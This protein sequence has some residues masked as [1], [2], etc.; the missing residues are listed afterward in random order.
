M[1]V[2]ERHVHCPA[3]LG[4]KLAQEFNNKDF[5]DVKLVVGGKEFYAHRMLLANQ[6][7]MFRIMFNGSQWVES[8]QEEITLAESRECVEVF[9][10]FLQFFYSARIHL[11]TDNI[12]AVRILADK[13]Q[14][15][16]LIK[17]CD[18]FV[19]EIIAH[20]EIDILVNWLVNMAN[21]G[22][23]M[24]QRCLSKLQLDFTRLMASGTS[25]GLLTLDLLA[26][27]VES[28]NVLV[29][30]ELMMFKLVARWI[31]EHRHASTQKAAINRLLPLIRFV[32]MTFDQL[33]AVES[34]E[35]GTKYPDLIMKHTF[36]A[37]KALAQMAVKKEKE[38]TDKDREE[39]RD[40][41]DTEQASKAKVSMIQP[42]LYMDKPW[43]NGYTKPSDTFLS[44]EFDTG[45]FTCPVVDRA[46]QS[47]LITKMTDSWH[48]CYKVEVK[49]CNESE[50]QVINRVMVTHDLSCK[51]R[52]IPDDIR[53][54]E[55][56]VLTGY[57]PTD[58][59]ED[60][61]LAFTTL[62]I[63]KHLG[64]V[65]PQALKTTSRRRIKFT[66]ILKPALLGGSKYVFSAAVYYKDR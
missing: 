14:H 20:D 52:I 32:L 29:C 15:I 10:D 63:K 21:L 49:P 7:E 55:L 3:S 33:S 45:N 22:D 12:V 2:R 60:P 6:S 42:R 50:D 9:H 23:R 54:Y 61:D 46:L 31:L 66:E 11:T 48:M 19:T 16:Q 38:D 5:S 25:R 41:V 35:L 44:S 28:A 47:C 59:A 57:V 56:V 17:E 64:N 37:Y 51:Y 53:S 1:S 8:T 4:A 36:M 27:I 62:T 13:Y 43:G 26:K 30:N 24:E 34:S 58:E 39:D 40:K 65:K 18:H